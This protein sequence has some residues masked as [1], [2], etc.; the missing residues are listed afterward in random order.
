MLANNFSTSTCFAIFELVKF[1]CFDS[2]FSYRAKNFSSRVRPAN[3]GTCNSR[4]SPA[5]AELYPTIRSIETV[6][7]NQIGITMVIM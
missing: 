2:T 4:V 5:R 3:A 6:W 1:M 7:R